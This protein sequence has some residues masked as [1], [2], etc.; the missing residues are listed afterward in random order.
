VTLTKERIARSLIFLQALGVALA[1]LF[2]IAMVDVLY[3]N[4]HI[5]DGG[6][7]FGYAFVLVEVCA[8]GSLMLLSLV[9]KHVRHRRQQRWERLRPVLAA[10]ISHHLTGANSLA[11]LRALRRRHPHETQ[12]S[13]AEMI[14]RVQGI[15]RL[16]LSELAETLGVVD[17]WKR[18]Y[19]SRVVSRRR[20]AI[21]RLGGLDG[22]AAIDTLMLAL[23]DLDDEVKLEASRALI[24]RSG[25]DEL[26]AVFRTA[27]RES[28]LVRAVLTESLR[29]HVMELCRHAVPEALHSK[30]TRTVRTALE[31]VRAWGKALPLSQVAPLLEHEDKFVRAAALVVVPQLVTPLVC[32]PQVLRCLADPE[33]QVR[34][35]A[36]EVAGSLRLASAIPALQRCLEEASAE[37][38]VAAAYALARTGD[39]GMRILERRVISARDSSA[40]A[41]LEALEQA[42]SQRMHAAA[43]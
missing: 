25:P 16:R 40:C 21:S 17:A 8:I 36:A 4:K 2:T 15:A 31:V 19:G 22:D 41:A 28:L 23:S 39:E 20:D 11:E 29:P 42:R 10:A 3:V 1:F 9:I 32:E 26:T 7:A 35:A 6:L 12:E 38:T 14:L 13:I 30:N 43:I 18:Q 27:L 5:A 33:E 34:A 24:R 37:A